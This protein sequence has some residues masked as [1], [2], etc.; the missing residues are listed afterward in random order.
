MKEYNSVS[1]PGLSIKDIALIGVMTATLEAGKY[2]LSFIPNVEIVSLL[3]ILYTLFFEGKTI[4]AIFCF[5]LLDGCIYGFGLWWIMYLYAWPLLSLVTSWFRKRGSCATYAILSGIFGLC[6]GALCALPY[7]FIGGLKTAITWWIAGIPY[8][9]IHC[10]GNF[11][12]C[13][14]LF[15]PLYWVLG[16]IKRDYYR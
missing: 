15:K 10:I 6:F 5:I 2:A 11:I 13:I 4:Y 8:D 7:L 12:L 16:R 1:K 3:V 9:I 14:V